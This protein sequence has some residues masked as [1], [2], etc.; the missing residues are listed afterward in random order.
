[1]PNLPQ[2]IHPPALTIL[3]EQ[4]WA[5]Y[6]R[7]DCGYRGEAPGFVPLHDPVPF[8]QHDPRW[9]DIPL[10]TSSYTV[11]SAGCAV[12]AAAMLITRINYDITPTDLVRW[13]NIHNGFTS[14][15]LLHWNKVADFQDGLE[16]INYH[17]WRS[18]AADV[19]KLRSL[20]DFGPQIVQVDYHPGGPLNTHF[21]LATAILP[22]DANHPEDIAIVDPFTGKPSTLLTTYA[23]PDWDLARAVYAVAEFRTA[24]P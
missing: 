4:T 11:T 18:T 13:L 24:T 3:A 22:G 10:G 8:S 15:G 19:N 7:T 23:R 2:D 1:M 5:S 6:E 9:A 12:T 20:L 14:G 21:V 17:V 16:F